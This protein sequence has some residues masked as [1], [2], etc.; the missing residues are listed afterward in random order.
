MEL[1][2]SEGRTDGVAGALC[3]PDN[4]AHFGEDVNDLSTW[5]FVHKPAM[6]VLSE[7]QK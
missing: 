2:N 5:P 4:A 7:G 6:V 3:L 1:E